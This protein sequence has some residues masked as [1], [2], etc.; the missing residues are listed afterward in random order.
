MI[1]GA[2]RDT[3]AAVGERI[4]QAIG[5]RPFDVGGSGPLRVTCSVGVASA[6]RDAGDPQGLVAEADAALLRAKAEGKDRVVVAG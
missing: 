1:P 6:P 5:G 3:A 2:D 4:R